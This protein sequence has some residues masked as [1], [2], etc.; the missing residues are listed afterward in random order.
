MIDLRPVS[1]EGR[2]WEHVERLGEEHPP[3]PLDSADYTMVRPAVLAERF[4]PVLTYM[5][6]VELE[7][8]RNILE[9]NLLLPDPPPV[10]RFFYADVW[11]PQETHHGLILDKL[12]CLAGLP[13]ALPDLT[14]ID[15]RL[16]L[17]GALGKAS[18]V[19][20]VS[21]MLYYLTGV[22]T[23]QSAILAYNKLHG[24]LMELGERAVAATV[25]GPIRRQERVISRTTRS[26]PR[27]CGQSWQRGRSGWSG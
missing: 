5:S 16:R 18:A 7:V 4:G 20:D 14:T 25:I 21:R 2:L 10:D 23:E 11:L 19:Q 3:I 6:R 12:Q 9:L 1:V 27:A 24:G 17:L 15:F 22:A 8:E 26:P 13:A